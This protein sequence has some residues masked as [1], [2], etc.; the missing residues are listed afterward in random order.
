MIKYILIIII[1]L[2][3]WCNSMIHI[4]SEDGM[5]H[6]INESLMTRYE[7]SEKDTTI[8][9]GN[10]VFKI[11]APIDLRHLSEGLSLDLTNSGIFVEVSEKI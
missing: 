6:G 8:H 11:N 10:V 1:L 3:G 7:R 2:Q 4:K 9:I 5:I